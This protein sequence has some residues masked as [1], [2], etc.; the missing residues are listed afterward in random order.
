ME[1]VQRDQLFQSAL[2][3]CD[4]HILE[5]IQTS[6]FRPF[7]DSKSFV[8]LPLKRSPGDILESFHSLESSLTREQYLGF[9]QTNFYCDQKKELSI[10]VREHEPLD[11]NEAVPSFLLNVKSR[12]DKVVSFCLDLKQRWKQLC[13]KFRPGLSTALLNCTSLIHLPHQ[14]FI[15]GGRFRECYYWDTLWVVKGLV[16]CDMLMS[17]RAATRNLLHLVKRFGFVPNGNRLYY[18]NRTQPPVLT[19]A[20]RVVYNALTS[21][22]DKIQWLQEATPLL[23]KELMFFHHHRSLSVIH[24]Q[25]SFSDRFLC[26][27]SALTKDPRP[28]S[29]LEDIETAE[30]NDARDKKEI[31]HNL[32][33]AAE[34]G[35]DFSSRWYTP[36]S[37][38]A[39][40]RTNKIV[41]I[42]LNSWLVHSERTLSD[43]Y[44]VLADADTMNVD[45]KHC[46]NRAT[47]FRNASERRSFDLAAL[48]WNRDNGGWSDFDLDSGSRTPIISA[49]AVM[50]I[51]A[52][53]ARKEWTSQDAT[54]FVKFISD[55][56]GLLQS[57][58]LAITTTK[59]N[60]QWDFPNCWSPL[61]ELAVVALQQVEADFP[62]SGAGSVAR[63]IALRFVQTVFRGWDRND[64]V[65]HEK[66]DS[67]SSA[68]ERGAGGE[69][70]PQTGF[71]WTNGTVL[72]LMKNF[73]HD[74]EFFQLE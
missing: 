11:C 36:E 70:E 19:E 44:T 73:C 58:G 4:S 38:L 37:S 12:P 54:N 25:S 42:C 63:E 41:P 31:F 13:R 16:A 22:D 64:G 74:Q 40:I 20:V 8:D 47:F 53:C 28:E 71:G 30:L 57:G 14:F 23:G 5:T 59:S 32:A 45:R 3:F 65:I 66:Y 60:Q 48:C 27:Y 15:P 7:D 46:R 50:P 62:G 17:A 68:G 2:I 56:S 67:T 26:V 24:P 55:K 72:C 51:W 34:S 35:W 43:F 29:Y 39:H 69:Y 33:S 49:A 9:L 1:P 61:V 52:G 6:P 21:K 18:L 10:Y